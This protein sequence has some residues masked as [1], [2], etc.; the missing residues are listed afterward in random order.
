MLAAEANLA[1]PPAWIILAGER[2]ATGEWKG[3]LQ[4]RYRPDVRVV[5]LGGVAS[6]P[7]E[8]V[9][10]T[11]PESGAVAWLCAGTTCLPPIAD[12]AGIERALAM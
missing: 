4:R 5:D 8:I 3:A 11:A 1:K 6:P 9:K 10:G 7:P 12:L 2:L